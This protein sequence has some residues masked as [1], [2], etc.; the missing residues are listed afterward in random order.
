MSVIEGLVGE[1]RMKVYNYRNACYILIKK[2]SIYLRNIPCNVTPVTV[3][4][5]II[6]KN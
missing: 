5:T 6:V 2:I 1:S 3:G 4:N